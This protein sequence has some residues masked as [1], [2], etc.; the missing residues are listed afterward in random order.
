MEHL[1]GPSAPA[2]I[3]N[4]ILAGGLVFY[5]MERFM[6]NA[7]L[8]LHNS[9]SFRRITAALAHSLFW[10]NIAFLIFPNVFRMFV[11][12][13]LKTACS[14]TMPSVIAMRCRDG[15]VRPTNAVRERR[16]YGTCNQCSG[17]A[18]SVL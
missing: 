1:E 11:A 7:W 15:V 13:F 9:S 10:G 12:V 3:L 2:E 6:P 18:T 17:P 14:H 8:P 4:Q 5:H 16:G